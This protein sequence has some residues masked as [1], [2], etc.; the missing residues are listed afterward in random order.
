MYDYIRQAYGLDFKPGQRVHH[1][2]G[3]NLPDGTVARENKN[4]AHHVMVR[5]D[6]RKHSDPCH[7]KALDVLPAKADA[8]EK[9]HD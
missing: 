1:N 6:G 9:P 8:K 7:P 4:Q 5:F 3:C 2:E